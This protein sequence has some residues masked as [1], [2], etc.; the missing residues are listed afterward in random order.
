MRV[1]P[2][3][4]GASLV[5]A[6]GKRGCRSPLRP[7]VRYES[8][9]LPPPRS[10]SQNAWRPAPLQSM[11]NRTSSPGRTWLDGSTM[12]FGSPLSTQSATRMPPD[13]RRTWS[14]G[15]SDSSPAAPSVAMASTFGSA[16]GKWSAKDC[17]EPRQAMASTFSAGFGKWS[18]KDWNEPRQTMASTFGS[19]F[20]K[21]SVSASWRRRRT[22]SPVKAKHG[23][24]RGIPVWDNLL[25]ALPLRD[26]GPLAVASRACLLQLRDDLAR[27]WA[28]PLHCTLCGVAFRL[29][30]CQA[31]CVFHPGKEQVSMTVDSFGVGMMDVSWSCCGKGMAYSVGIN[32][33][34]PKAEVP[35]CCTRRRHLAPAQS[36]REGE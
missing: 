16:F 28:R 34:C 2:L 31:G 30:T 32:M 26:A 14:C 1:A 35:G 10:V 5:D 20:G 36:A 9:G 12:K 8:K 23:F 15:F 11:R 6:P 24:L 21:G 19:G 7:R 4:L 3:P 25:R 22:A 17:A 27:A 33:P 13:F 29:G 18:T